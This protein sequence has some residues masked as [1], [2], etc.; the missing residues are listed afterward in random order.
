[1]SLQ[2]VMTDKELTNSVLFW[3]NVKDLQVFT[4]NSVFVEEF[5]IFKTE[6]SAIIF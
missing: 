4:G 5:N 3:A 2:N 1:M 6:S